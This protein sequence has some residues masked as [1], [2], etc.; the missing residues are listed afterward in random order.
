MVPEVDLPAALDRVSTTQPL[1]EAV[2]N[3]VTV[4]GVANVI[5]HWGALPV[6]ADTRREVAEMVATAD[7]CLL[8]TGDVSE[9]GEE[10]ML[11][12]GRA[13]NESGVPVVLDPVGVGAT[14]TRTAVVE[15]LV[16]TLD[17]TVINGNRA[18]IGAIA[19]AVGASDSEGERSDIRG[20]EAVGEDTVEGIAAT[21]LACARATDTIVVV[22]GETDVLADGEAAYTVAAGHP[23]LGRVVGTGCMLGGTLATFVASLDASFEAALTG[24]LAY[25]LAGERAAAGEYGVYAGPASYEVAFRDAIADLAD[26]PSGAGGREGSAIDARIDRRTIPE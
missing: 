25:G 10:T 23:M 7:G 21:A 9:S 8:N 22:S 2:T 12:A 15:R 6:M 17:I 14:P 18:E 20:V 26:A 4:N 24:T 5:L 16:E 11:A 3:P 1:I 13:A 19:E